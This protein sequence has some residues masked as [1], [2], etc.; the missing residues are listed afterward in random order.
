MDSLIEIVWIDE[1]L[2]VQIKRDVYNSFKDAKGEN[3]AL[4]AVVDKL[5]SDV[6][7]F[8]EIA[9]VALKERKFAV[10]IV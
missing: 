5:L 3:F 7:S 2:L 6:S 8:N 1:G 4:G 9:M 10:E